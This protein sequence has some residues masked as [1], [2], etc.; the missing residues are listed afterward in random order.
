MSTSDKSKAT[1]QLRQLALKGSMA[2][3][4]AQSTKLGF[5]AI[6]IVVLSRLLSPDDYGIFAMAISVIGFLEILRS[7]GL[8]E[9]IVKEPILSD[10]QLTALWIVNSLTGLGFTLFIVAIAPLMAWF[11]HDSRV[12]PIMTALAP[13]FMIA[14]VSIQHN[15]LLRREM[16]FKALLTVEVLFVASSV[17]VSICLAWLGFD[18]WALVVGTLTGEIVSTIL[19]WLIEPW[20]P[21]L[22]ANFAATAKMLRFGLH[23]QCAN[24][25]AVIP[26]KL[27]NILVGRFFGGANLGIYSRAFNLIMLPIDQLIVSANMVAIPTLSRLRDDPKRFCAYYLKALSIMTH[28][29]LPGS[30]YL[31]IMSEE[32]IALVLGN[33]WTTAVP[34]FQV[35]SLVSFALP[36]GESHKWVNIALGRGGRMLRISAFV[37]ITFVLALFVGLAWGPIGVAASITISYWLVFLPILAFAFKGSPVKYLSVLKTLLKPLLV[38]VFVGLALVAYK[39][40]ISFMISATWQ[41]LTIALVITSLTM[42]ITSSVLAGKINPLQHLRTQ[43]LEL[44]TGSP[45]P[46]RH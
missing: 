12:L 11:Y 46:Q 6:S 10:E 44:K 21:K 38:A 42:V 33:K 20:R 1:E 3:L 18:Y 39:I 9:A 29:S 45:N 43:L 17:S 2:T 41:S 36:I 23:M 25:L 7:L 15:A 26:I 13:T 5:S 22:P 4:I 37:S 14:C 32:I 34:I 40:N 35:L 24:I 27:D 28:F 8:I 16:R 31:L 19:L 30:M